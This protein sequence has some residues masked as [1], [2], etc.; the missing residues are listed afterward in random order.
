MYVPTYYSERKGPDTDFIL[1][2]IAD[3]TGK[4]VPAP[5]ATEPDGSAIPYGNG[6]LVDPK[7]AD[8]PP[9]YLVGNGQNSQLGGGAAPAPVSSAALSSAAPLSSSMPASSAAP[10]STTTASS[11][12]ETSTTSS[13]TDSAPAVT[14]TNGAGSIKAGSAALLTGVVALLAGW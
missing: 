13:A 6:R 3:A 1:Q 8:A 14:K 4:L 12:I 2:Q 10:F 11:T 9:A 5:I 7:Q